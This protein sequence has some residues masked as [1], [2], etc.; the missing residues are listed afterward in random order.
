VIAENRSSA[1][2]W[3]DLKQAYSLA[4]DGVSADEILILGVQ[5]YKK[6]LREEALTVQGEKLAVQQE[7]KNQGTGERLVDQ[8]STELGYVMSLFEGDCDGNW[9]CVRKALREQ[10]QEDGFSDKDIQTALQIE[11]KYG[12]NDIV[13]LAYHE[14]F[15]EEDWACTRAFYREQYMSTREKGKPTK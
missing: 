3:G 5:D 9:A 2:S 14:D 4:E 12:F 13:V 7:E 15:C 10:E 6:S 1:D 8:F 11:A